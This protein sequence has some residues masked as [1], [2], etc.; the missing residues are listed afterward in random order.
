ME[1]THLLLL[2]RAV[3][4]QT[5]LWRWG[6]LGCLAP[7]PQKRWQI[8]FHALGASVTFE[9]PCL[10]LRLT[11]SLAG[12]GGQPRGDLVQKWAK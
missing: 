5:G 11:A 7:A 8:L 2:V 4:L 12:C 3:G 9:T 1:I 10:K 6:P